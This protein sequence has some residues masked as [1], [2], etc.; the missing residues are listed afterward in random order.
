MKEIKDEINPYLYYILIFYILEKKVTILANL[1]LALNVRNCEKIKSE[2]F[3]VNCKVDM[4][5]LYLLSMIIF[6]IGSQAQQHLQKKCVKCNRICVKK[7]KLIWSHSIR[8]L[9]L[10]RELF[11][12]PFYLSKKHVNIQLQ[13]CMSHMPGYTEELGYNQKSLSV[14]EKNRTYIYIYIHTYTQYVS[15]SRM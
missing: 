13:L 10:V 15:E 3:R 14:D 1:K 12:K 8:I 9:W 2:C 5:M 11:S 4:M 6:T 7:I